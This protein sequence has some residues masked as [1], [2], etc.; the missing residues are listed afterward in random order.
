[1]DKTMTSNTASA[2]ATA[3]AATRRNYPPPYHLKHKPIYMLTY[4][5]FD[6]VYAANGAS[7]A[8]Y[9]SIGLAQ[10]RDDNATPDEISAKVWRHSDAKWSRMS[11]ELPLHRVVDLC[12]LLVRTLFTEGGNAGKFP[13]GTF[14]H[15]TEDMNVATTH[16]IPG[17]FTNNERERLAGRLRV[18]KD[19][20]GEAELQAAG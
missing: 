10:W 18:L 14:D 8:K 9:L 17:E 1:M 3:V 4:E 6:G 2:Q 13:R 16:E 5:P 19:I 15:Q 20:L 7:D 12:I 11:E